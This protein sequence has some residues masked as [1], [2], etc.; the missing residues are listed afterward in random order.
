MPCRC[1]VLTA[2]G[3]QIN[4][5]AGMAVVDVSLKDAVPILNGVFSEREI[6]V[7]A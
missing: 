2:S 6:A 7:A 3:R 4:V 5:Q 1:F